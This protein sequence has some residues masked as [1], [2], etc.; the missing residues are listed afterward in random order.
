FACAN[1]R[2]QGRKTP[3]ITNN[4]IH[5]LFFMANPLFSK[6]VRH[7]LRATCQV[8][9][10][11]RQARRPRLVDSS[12]TDRTPDRVGSPSGCDNEEVSPRCSFAPRKTN[13]AQRGNWRQRREHSSNPAHQEGRLGNTPKWHDSSGGRF[14]CDNHLLRKN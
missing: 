9:K 2:L 8:E 13:E 14:N 11:E 4:T 6:C 12:A 5:L 1:V 7:A 10:A 3:N